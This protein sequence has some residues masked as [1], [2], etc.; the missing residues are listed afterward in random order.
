M[1]S[2]NRLA[3]SIDSAF[4]ESNHNPV[5]DFLEETLLTGRLEPKK[6]GQE[7]KRIELTYKRSISTERRGCQNVIREKPGSTCHSR[8]ATSPLDLLKLFLSDEIIH[9]VVVHTNEKNTAF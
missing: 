6:K 2:T 8:T 9:E 5:Q 3:N 1:Y 4:D 7:E